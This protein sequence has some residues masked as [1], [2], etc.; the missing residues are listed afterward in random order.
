MYKNRYI[1]ICRISK[2]QDSKIS[3]LLNLVS[4]TFSFA[5]NLGN[6]HGNEYHVAMNNKPSITAYNC[7][8]ESHK[9]DIKQTKP[10]SKEYIL[11]NLYKSKTKTK[12]SKPVY[13]GRNQ[14]NIF[15][16]RVGSMKGH[17]V[18]LLRCW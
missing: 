12:K 1:F 11:H 9:H 8:N 18:G 15:W 2:K 14:N 10:E 3:L 13:P 16:W 6:R 5:S 7:K 17:T 4:L